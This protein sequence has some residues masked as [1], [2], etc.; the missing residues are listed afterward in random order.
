MTTTITKQLLKQL[1]EEMNTALAAVASKHGLNITVGNARF[2]PTLATFKVDVGIPNASG[3]PVNAQSDALAR[4][5]KQASIDPKMFE[6]EFMACGSM[7]HVTGYKP[8]AHMYPFVFAA[9][10]GTSY[11]MGAD[12]VRMMLKSKHNVDLPSW[13]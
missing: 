9:K 10:N 3:V 1:R 13:I 6:T 5:C 4:L 7:G 8:K 12:M 2:S 11:L